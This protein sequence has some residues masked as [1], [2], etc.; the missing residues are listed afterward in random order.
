MK[1]LTD[2]ILHDCARIIS[3]HPDLSPDFKT[4]LLLGLQT[5][6]AAMSQPPMVFDGETASDY[7]AR[8][9]D[10]QGQTPKPKAGKR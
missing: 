6:D 9:L 1:N 2:P 5:I 3:R 8:R 10:E 4:R 7:G